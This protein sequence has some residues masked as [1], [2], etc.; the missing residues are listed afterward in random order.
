MILSLAQPALCLTAGGV[1]SA[2]QAG[3]AKV[4]AA[5]VRWLPA[6]V[7]LAGYATITNRG[8]RTIVL[9]AASSPMFQEISIHRSIQAAGNV[10]MSPVNEITIAPHTTLDFASRGFHL[11]L[12][13]PREPIDL[14]PDIP[15]TLRFADGSSLTAEFQVRKNAEK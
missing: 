8:D 1:R 13:R 14:K 5:W 3:D 15:I 10:Q 7:P 6:D 12:M 4:D 11:M 2:T 9:T